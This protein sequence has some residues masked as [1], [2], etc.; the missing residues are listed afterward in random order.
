MPNRSDLAIPVTRSHH[1]AAEDDGVWTIV[2]ICIIGA[3]V[4]I[5]CAASF[6]SFDALPMV[7]GQI[8]LG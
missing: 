1:R 2:A 6:Q 8:P 5:Y 3:L 4:T 7:I